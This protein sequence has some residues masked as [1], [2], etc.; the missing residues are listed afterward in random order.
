M[1]M[2]IKNKKG[3]GKKEARRDTVAAVYMQSW[4]TSS[5][6][7][8]EPGLTDTS[9]LIRLPRLTAFDFAR[10]TFASAS[11]ATAALVAVCCYLDLALPDE[12][13]SE[14]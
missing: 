5:S 10:F 12:A 3:K 7:R 8:H 4:L 13:C 2:K 11:A 6:R 9:I 1:E 14:R